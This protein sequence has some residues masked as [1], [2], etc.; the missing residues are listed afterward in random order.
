MTDP[1]VSISWLQEH[2]Q[3]PNIALIDAT[4]RLPGAPGDPRAEFLQAH[5][6][7]SVFFDIDEIRDRASLYPHMAAD[8]ADFAMAARRLGVNQDNVVIVYDRLGLFSAPR[9]WWN[10]R[11]MGHARTYVLDGGFPAWA[12]QGLPI[13]SGWP[14]PAHGDFKARPAMGLITSLPQMKALVADRR[15]LLIDA[16][17]SERF[18]GQAPEPRPGL[19]AGHMPGAVNTPWSGFVDQNGCLRSAADLERLFR[20][21][22]VDPQRPA[23]ATCGSGVSAAVALLALARLGNATASLYDGSWAE[24]GAQPDTEV[25]EGP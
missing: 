11:A 23:T 12:A 10:F 4:W 19:R 7:G 3:D 8:P 21:R 14:D 5:I 15:A 6:P 22:G 20:D 9:V 13:E 25:V 2:L 17:P 18:S 16:R 24:W 1:V